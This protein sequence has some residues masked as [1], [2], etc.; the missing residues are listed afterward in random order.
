MIVRS[1][2]DVC[3][4][5]VALVT[6]LVAPWSSGADPCDTSTTFYCDTAQNEHILA[7]AGFGGDAWSRQRILDMGAFFYLREQLFPQNIP[8]PQ[9]EQ[10]LAAYSFGPLSTFGK[11]IAILRQQFCNTNQSYCTD[12]RG[13]LNHVNAQLAEIKLLRAT[14]S[15]RQLEAVML[16]FWFNH[17][18]VDGSVGVARLSAQHYERESIAPHALGRFEDL[19]RSI[20]LAPAMLDYLDLKRSRR[21]NLNENFARE[22]LELHTVGKEGTYD[23]TDVQEVTKILTGYISNPPDFVTQ[24]LPNRHVTGVK[25]VTLEDTEPWVFDGNLGC[26][27]RPAADF[28]TEADV[29]FCLLALHPKTA[30]FVS[31]KLINRFVTSNPRDDLVERAVGAW[32]ASGGNLRGVMLATLVSKDFLSF[33]ELYGDKF[34]RP[35][36]FSAKVIRALGDDVIGSSQIV[37]QPANN[38]LI[39]NSFNGVLGDLI[40]M[41]ESLYKASPPTGYPESSTAWASAGG[42]LV[43]LDEVQRLIAPIGNAASRFGIPQGADSA[44]IVDALADRFIPQGITAPTRTATI[45]LLD[46]LPSNA[47]RNQRARQAATLLLSSPEFLTH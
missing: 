22:L 15:R 12:R 43:R 10:A 16:D 11:P 21:G 14:L 17:F 8:D 46:S 18:N 1:I 32:Q 30:E 5:T 41:G 33:T 39:N 6:L 25:T 7:R 36:V 27:G 37:D 9:F 44:G 4:Q 3:A 29:L 19:L 31:R 2:R 47:G 28:E 13:A 42:T 26:D 20:A 45:D 35:Q 24:Y 23:E 34:A 40:Q 38:N